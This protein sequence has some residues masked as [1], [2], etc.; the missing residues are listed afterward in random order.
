M[1]V[2]GVGLAAAAASMLSWYALMTKMYVPPSGVCNDQLPCSIWLMSGR[3]R[4][5]CWA[6]ISWVMPSEVRVFMS[7]SLTACSDML[8]PLSS[9]YALALLVKQC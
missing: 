1:L 9:C 3:V 8:F 2:A 6:I 7:L 5:V 4:P